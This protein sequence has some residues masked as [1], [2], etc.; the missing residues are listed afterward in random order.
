MEFKNR[1]KELRETLE[2][3][4]NEFAEELGLTRNS[5]AKY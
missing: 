1:L 3:T 5:I 4:Q 2:K